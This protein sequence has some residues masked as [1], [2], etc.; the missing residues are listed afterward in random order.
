MRAVKEMKEFHP[1]IYTIYR[2]SCTLVIPRG[3]IFFSTSCGEFFYESL[4]IEQHLINRPS[5]S[6]LMPCLV[7]AQ[8]LSYEK[9]LH[10]NKPVGGTQFHMNGL[11]RRHVLTDAKGNLEWPIS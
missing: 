3:I 4:K 10:E 6:Y 2:K 11:A 9:N 1:D 8:N 7:L 5:P